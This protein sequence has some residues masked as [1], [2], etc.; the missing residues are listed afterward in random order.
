[1]SSSIVPI[2]K[3]HGILVELTWRVISHII[4]VPVNTRVVISFNRDVTHGAG[5]GGELY[6]RESRE[7]FQIKF[8]HDQLLC[9][10]RK[11]EV[12]RSN[13]EERVLEDWRFVSGRVH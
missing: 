7:R 1:M 2:G 13:I 5:S 11:I 8:F 9:L 6:H 12:C 4:D 10:D 3:F